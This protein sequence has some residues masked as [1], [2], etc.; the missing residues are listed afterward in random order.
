MSATEPIAFHN[1]L[2]EVC[3]IKSPIFL[4]GLAAIS[5]PKLVSAV[6]NAGGMGIV[7]GLRAAPRLLR[8]QVQP[9]AIGSASMLPRAVSIA[10]AFASGP[11]ARPSATIT[12]RSSIPTRAKMSRR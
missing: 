4:A 2:T 1:S 11:S 6:S 5:G 3:G 8:H 9:N 12:S 7:G 10:A